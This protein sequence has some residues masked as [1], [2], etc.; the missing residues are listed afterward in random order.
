MFYLSLTLFPVTLPTLEM[1]K[2]SISEKHFYLNYLKFLWGI[3]S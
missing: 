2:S 3:E 1:T